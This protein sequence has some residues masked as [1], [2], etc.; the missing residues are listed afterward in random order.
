MSRILFGMLV[1]L[2]LAG[3]FLLGVN[4]DLFLNPWIKGLQLS[5]W[6]MFTTE[7]YITWLYARNFMGFVL[8]TVLVSALMA[9]VVAVKK[10]V[11]FR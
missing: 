5:W 11:L 4:L 6:N 1:F 9:S 3:G 10:E 7:H 2:L 8:L